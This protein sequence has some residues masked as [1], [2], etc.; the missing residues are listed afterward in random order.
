MRSIWFSPTHMSTACAT[1]TG[2]PHLTAVRAT[3]QRLRQTWL[4]HLGVVGAL[5]LGIALI[6]T[7]LDGR[8]FATKLVYSLCIGTVCTLLVDSTRLAMAWVADLAARRYP[9]TN[10]VADAPAITGWRGAIPGSLLATV[11]G[12]PAGMWLADRFTGNQSESLLNWASPSTRMTVA[13]SVVAMTISVVVISTLE[14]LGRARAQAEAAQRQAAETQLRLLQSQLEPHML[15]NT[16]ANLR[17]LIGLDAQRAQNMLDHLIAFLRATLNASR[18]AQHPLATEFERLADYLALMG[19]RMGPRLQ[20]SLELPAALADVMV[21][22]LLL[23]PL[24]ENAIKH[25]LE[26][27][28]QGGHIRVSARAEGHT[29]VL[30]V[31]DTGAGLATADSA[32][33]PASEGTH[34]GL[35]QVRD[36]LA[37]LHGSAASLSLE[38]VGDTTNSASHSAS[39]LASTHSSKHTG[40][41][42]TVRLPLP[43]ASTDTK[44][45][46]PSK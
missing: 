43:V 46:N 36:R 1:P 24:V 37:T 8:G 10:N 42:A 16:L 11:L 44:P 41:L 17:V 19:I 31:H 14:R 33:A 39:N 35:Q 18:T 38:P 45:N 13:F 7:A 4:L 29:P 32:A 9:S 23:Q 2:Q 6:L 12:P 20:V 28:V 27:H 25:G 40:T 34:F 3:L 26:P 21:P 30:Q 22:P 5:C 15:F